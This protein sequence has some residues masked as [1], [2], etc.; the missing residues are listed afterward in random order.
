MPD[1][2]PI[3]FFPGVMGSR[4]YFESSQKFWDPDSNWRMLRWLPQWPFRSDEDNRL[5]LNAREPAGVL[6]DPSSGSVPASMVPYGWGGVPWKFYGSY[7]QRLQTLAADGKAFAVG[8][9]WRQDIRWLGEYAAQN[10]NACLES[11]GAARLWLVAHS[12]G[13]LVVR[14]ALLTDPTL[15]PR[16]DKVVFVCPP[17]AGAVVLYRRL[18]TGMVSGLDGGLG[19]L[20]FRMVLGNSR[21]AFV[22]NMS[23][24]PGPMQLLPGPS[25]PRDETQR[26][27]NDALAGGLPFDG[28]YGDA[29]CPPGINDPA[30]G[31]ADDARADLAERLLDVADFFRWLP[32]PADAAPPV[33]VIYGT[34]LK[35]DARIVFAGGQ[36]QPGISLHGDGTVPSLSATVPPV[37][38]ERQFAVDSIEHSLACA[39][40]RVQDQT[41]AILGGQ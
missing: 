13:A 10:L 18:F 12:M 39:D 31:L 26:F 20:G 37:P 11:T 32:P 3:V 24:L 2:Y 35:T 8:Y 7:L 28:L 14:A 40:S 5:Q 6:I 15:V 1:Q 22:G 38:A 4:L 25:F 29:D 34:G 9:D 36:P 41:A 19:D 23:G 16:V 33:W 21:E 30:L 27:W 17:I